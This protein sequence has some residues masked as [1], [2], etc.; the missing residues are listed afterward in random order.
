MG[1]FPIQP[2]ERDPKGLERKLR[3]RQLSRLFGS[4]RVAEVEFIRYKLWGLQGHGDD[5][6]PTGALPHLL[7]SHGFEHLL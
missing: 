6:D 2:R 7:S 5:D 4:D 3:P 1:H